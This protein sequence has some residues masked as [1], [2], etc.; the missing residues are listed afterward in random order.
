MILALM[1]QVEQSEATPNE[2]EQLEPVGLELSLIIVLMT[3][4]ILFLW[5]SGK[6]CVSDVLLASK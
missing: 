6:S 3:M 2:G 5:E 4:S 1:L